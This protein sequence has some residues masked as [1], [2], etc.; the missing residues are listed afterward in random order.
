[1]NFIF[2]WDSRYKQG[3]VKCNELNLIREHF[4]VANKAAKFSHN[5]F[6]PQRK[7]VITPQGRFDIGMFSEIYKFIKSLNINFNVTTTE[8]FIKKYKCSYK[9]SISSNAVLNMDL[10]DYQK[11]ACKEAFENGRGV[12]VL[13]TASGK[14]LTMA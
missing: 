7:Y 14:T 5:R 6:I 13:P 2:D 8:Q 11:S 12:I 9:N 4:S 10:R 1:M 3:I